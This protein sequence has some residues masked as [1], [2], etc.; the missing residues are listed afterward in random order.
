MRAWVIVGC[1][2]S[3]LSA[4]GA[5]FSNGIPKDESFFPLAVWVQSPK[6]AERFKAAGVNAYVG[7]WKGP[8]EEQLAELKR[9][10]MKLICAQNSVGLAHKDDPMIIGWLQH[11]EPDN[12]QSLGESK[13]WGPPVEP[14][15]V[16]ER[17]EAMRKADPTRPIIL[18]LGQGVAWDNWIGRGVRRNHPEDY[19]DYVKGG[20]IVSFDIYPATHDH[21]EVEGKLEFVGR[22]VKRLREWAGPQ[23]VVWNCVEAKTGDGDKRVTPAQLRAEVW[24]SLIHGSK[25]IIYFVHQF[26]PVFREASVLEDS[27]LLKGFTE[28]N[29]QV[30]ELAP[31]LNAKDLP[32]KVS[33]PD[34]AAMGKRRGS[35]AYVFAVGMSDK[36]AEAT[37]E[38]PELAQGFSVEVLGEGRK[39]T[40]KGRGFTDKFAGY[41][42]RTYR[43]VRDDAGGGQR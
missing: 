41:E 27:E 31:V 28:V 2:L 36:N 38:I 15:K 5:E 12:A 10:G 22:G 9:A 1:V 19:V 32:L 13:G 16:I 30:T 24:M 34:V 7:L 25:G 4:A 8:T 37:F 40:A 20:D 17:Y 26:K 11:D 29:R 14:A 6:N 3:L 33:S 35:D 23:R 21:P 18:N 42:A 43:I 39:L